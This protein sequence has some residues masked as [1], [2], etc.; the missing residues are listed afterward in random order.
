MDKEIDTDLM[1]FLRKKYDASGLTL[2]QLGEKM[3]FEPPT[4]RQAAHQFLRVSDPRYSSLRRFAKATEMPMMDLIPSH[5]ATCP[6]CQT[7]IACY[8]GRDVPQ[9]EKGT[10][11]KLT[12]R[13]P[14]CSH[15]FV[16]AIIRHKDAK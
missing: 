9:P 3:D 1:E 8:G 13:C 5:L 16:V 11:V 6:K 4:A 7:E 2:Q 10:A 14:N 15:K 12:G